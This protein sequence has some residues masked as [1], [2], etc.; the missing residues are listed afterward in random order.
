MYV[1]EAKAKG[2]TRH[3]NVEAG[4]THTANAKYFPE[5]FLLFFFM[6]LFFF[7]SPAPPA[8]PTWAAAVPV[9]P[10]AIYYLVKWNIRME[11]VIEIQ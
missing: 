9:I 2:I 8:P 4:D 7:N 11:R 5:L 3:K 10:A 1:D 6:L